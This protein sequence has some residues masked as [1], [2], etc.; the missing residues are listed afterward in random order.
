MILLAC[1]LDIQDQALY[2]K[3][4]ALNLQTSLCLCERLTLLIHVCSTLKV[5]GE[6][7]PGTSCMS[8][9]GVHDLDD[10]TGDYTDECATS[11]DSAVIMGCKLPYLTKPSPLAAR[12]P[13]PETYRKLDLSTMDVVHPYA[14]VIERPNKKTKTTEPAD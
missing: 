9:Y 14:S 10:N 2:C 11:G 8:D 5:E 4:Y 1:E 6:E 3:L 12:V 7:R 13:S